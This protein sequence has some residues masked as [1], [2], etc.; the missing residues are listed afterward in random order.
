[1]MQWDYNDKPKRM[2]NKMSMTFVTF[3]S[4]ACLCARTNSTLPHLTSQTTEQRLFQSRSR[5]LPGRLTRWHRVGSKVRGD[6]PHPDSASGTSTHTLEHS[7]SN[8][9][10]RQNLGC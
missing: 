5:R 8:R 1:M 4:P 9:L 2:S 10:Q 6:S 7:S 3:L